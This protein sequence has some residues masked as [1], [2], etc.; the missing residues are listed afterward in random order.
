MLCS[1]DSDPSLPS[2]VLKVSY[3][4]DCESFVPLKSDFV[5]DAHFTDLDKVFDPPLTS[6]PFITPSFSSTPMNTTNSDLTLVAS[7]LALAQC[8]WLEM[9]E[10][11]KGYASVIEDDSLDWSKEPSLVEPYLEQAP[12]G[13]LCGDVMMGSA[14]PS[15]RHIDSICTEA[16]DLTPISSPFTHS[17]LLCPMSS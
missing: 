4:D 14:T 5:D 3:Y 12:F 17:H 10:S 9:G 13:E 15:N 7:T 2:P 16:L 6:S 1:S 11:S 8:T